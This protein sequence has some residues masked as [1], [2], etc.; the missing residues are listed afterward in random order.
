MHKLSSV[1]MTSILDYKLKATLRNSVNKD[2]RTEITILNNLTSL[3][4]SM[5]KL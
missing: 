3:T 1:N 5:I 4:N 2:S